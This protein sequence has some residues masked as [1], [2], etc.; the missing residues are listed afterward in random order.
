MT[1]LARHPVP[2]AE[3]LL[4]P[5]I[6]RD[7][8]PALAEVPEVS[9]SGMRDL[10]AFA[11]HSPGAI[12]TAMSR[13]RA[14]GL[15]APFEDPA[16]VTRYRTGAL[17]RS[18]SR[19]VRAERPDGF[20]L[21]VFSF[22]TEQVR[23]RQVVREALKLHG[24]QKLAQNVYIHGRIDTIEL[25]AVLREEGL[26]EHVWLFRVPEADDPALRRK[27]T[28]LFD[29]TS[30]AAQLRAFDLDLVQFLDP[31]LDDDS[32]A[33][34]LLYAGPVHYR[35]TWLD[36]PPLPASYLPPDYPLAEVRGRMTAL[37][38]ARA[39]ALIAYFRRAN[40]A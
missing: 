32:F 40:T 28:A 37:A 20:V 15:V 27:L 5:V 10:A 25:E 26:D 36:E 3:L 16:G 17:S 7:G 1:F 35:I 2:L 4:A 39:Q 31:G 21:A 19:A 12:R 38:A 8:L 9:G 24:F 18:V 22:V 34:R 33:R 11:G 23:E 29:L 6:F 14:S 30:R 13:L